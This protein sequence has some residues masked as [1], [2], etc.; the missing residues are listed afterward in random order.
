MWED[1]SSDGYCGC[2][3]SVLMDAMVS[4]N[5]MFCWDNKT[6]FIGYLMGVYGC[7]YNGDIM[8]RACNQ[9]YDVG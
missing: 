4:D 7:I 3:W 5:G 1:G 6:H 8:G 2:L 9:Q